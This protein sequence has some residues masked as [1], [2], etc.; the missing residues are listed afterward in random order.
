MWNEPEKHLRNGD[1]IM[2][3]IIY[4]KRSDSTETNDL[5]TTDTHLAIE[6]LE[7]NTD[8]IFQIKA[9]T[10]EGAGPWSSRLPFR[11]FG[12]CESSQ[13]PVVICG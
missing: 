13:H 3:E 2:Y 8:Y 9:Y 4:H 10:G 1:I 7:M 12:R 11:T 5:N 6:G